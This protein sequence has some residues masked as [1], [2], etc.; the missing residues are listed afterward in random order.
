MPYYRQYGWKE[1]DLPEA[2]KYYKSCI[3][4]PVYPTLTEIEQEL[5]I[6]KIKEFYNG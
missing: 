4:L 2:E 3:S 5:V 1:G 6:S